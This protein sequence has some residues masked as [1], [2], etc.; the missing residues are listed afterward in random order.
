MIALKGLP[1]RMPK[2]IRTILAERHDDDGLLQYCFA[3][4]LDKLNTKGLCRFGVSRQA[5][6][7]FI[8]WGDSHADAILLAVE[9]VAKDVGREGYFA[10]E[11][12][13]AP[14][15]GVFRPDAPRCRTFNDRILA[16][17]K[18]RPDI[19]TVILMARWGKNAAG[20]ATA[21]E[22][23]GFVPISDAE[24][25]A[26]KPSDN[27]AIFTRGLLRTVNALR[28]AH[29]KVVLVGPVPEIGAP[30]PQTLA[31]LALSGDSRKIGPT[32]A[33]YLQARKDGAAAV[34]SS[35][36]APRR[37]GGLSRPVP[38]PERALR[39]PQ[40]R[41]SALPGQPPSQRL[42]ARLLDPLLAGIFSPNLGPA[43]S[44]TG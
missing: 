7:S 35:G 17:V 21:D 15:L 41:H 38:V 40:G 4:P 12:S 37:K 3:L 23:K 44:G 43:S 18:S 34:S 11:P 36:P 30:V 14:L 33:H 2:P 25:R 42:R 9:D 6:P 39:G 32:L 22:G 16:F 27:A 31:R 28:A 29:K 26:R 24:G 19:D 10:G 1:D 20:T 8:L 5:K 13:C